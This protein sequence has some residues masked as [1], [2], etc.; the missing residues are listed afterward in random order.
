MAIKMIA[1]AGSGHIGPSFSCADIITCLYYNILNI[2]PQNPSWPERDRFILSKGHGVPS[3]YACLALKGFIE[4]TSLKSF[5]QINS[6]LQATPDVKRVS[7]LEAGAGSLGQG[8]SQ[9]LG[10]GLS[11]KINKNC[12]HVYVLMGDGELQ[13]GQVWEAA[14]AVSHFNP[15]NIT[16]I[17]DYNKMQL[18]GHAII[19]EARLV[20]K[21][22]AFGWDVCEIDGHNHDKITESLSV[23]PNSRPRVVIANTVKGKGVSFMENNP[24]YH[25]G[26]PT[27]ELI[28]EA[29]AELMKG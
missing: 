17:I 7:G 27:P 28:D 6:A 21:W 13:E 26:V 19:P 1:E 14:Q 22:K 16:A 4:A 23:R 10:M 15:G 18:D 3:L 9:A 29:I 24:V 12:A 25:A 5:R 20:E 2:D 11:F 8:L